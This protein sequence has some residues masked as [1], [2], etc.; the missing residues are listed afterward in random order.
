MFSRIISVGRF[1]LAYL[2]LKG[3]P[4]SQLH[5]EVM[6]GSMSESA[7]CSLM[8]VEQIPEFVKYHELVKG[9]VYMFSEDQNSAV[10]SKATDYIEAN[11][12]LGEWLNRHIRWL[13][14]VTG[15]A[16]LHTGLNQIDNMIARDLEKSINRR[17]R[18]DNVVRRDD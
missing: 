4:V 11:P 8:K 12:I 14:S 2:G 10:V 18:K 16:R 7:L 1:F 13:G 9:L 15:R 5:S 17:R 3:L 6:A